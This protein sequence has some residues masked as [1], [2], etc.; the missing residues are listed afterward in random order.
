MILLADDD[1]DLLGVLHDGL[2]AKGFRVHCA[3]DGADL[4]LKMKALP[5]PPC[6]VV[7]DWT[8]ACDARW[9]L[10]A[11]LRGPERG[12]PVPIVALSAQ[13]VTALPAGVRL[14]RK[15]LAWSPLVSAVRAHCGTSCACVERDRAAPAAP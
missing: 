3:R 9:N 6:V 12:A 11:T 15:P 2:T 13:P 10:L 5:R 4:I 14:I 1:N 8:I 7:V